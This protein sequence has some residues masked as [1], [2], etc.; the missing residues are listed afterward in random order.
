MS[1]GLE[2]KPLDLSNNPEEDVSE[3]ASLQQYSSQQQTV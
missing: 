1:V 2:E 3:R